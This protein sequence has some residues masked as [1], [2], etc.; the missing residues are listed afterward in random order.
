M[1]NDLNPKQISVFYGDKEIE[2][3]NGISMFNSCNSSA[4]TTDVNYSCRQELC[5]IMCKHE[6]QIQNAFEYL[7]KYTYTKQ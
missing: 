1:Q 6:M 7:K 5:F 3:G 2:D 4:R